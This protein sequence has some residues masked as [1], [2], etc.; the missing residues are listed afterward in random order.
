MKKMLTGIYSC[1]RGMI[2]KTWMVMRLTFF[3]MF[4]FLV[5]VSAS[6]YSQQT[7]LN[8]RTENASLEEVFKMIQEQSEFDFFYKTDQ[9]RGNQKISVDYKSSNIEDVL[10]EVL[11]GTGLN[12]HIL[13]KDIVISKS[14]MS[15]SFQQQ[16]IEL[17]GQILD[18]NGEPLPGVTVV[19][20]GT[21]N[22]VI[23]D[24]NGNYLLSNVPANGIVVFSFVGMHTIEQEVNGQTTINITMEDE[25]I[26]LEE[27]V[28]IGYGTVKKSDLT[29]SVG[30]VKGDDIANR[31]VTQVSQAL[32]GTISGVMVTRNN[33]APGSTASIRIRG[34]TTI[35]NSEPLVIVDG[36]PVG[37]INDVNPNDIESISVLKDAASASIYGSRAA[38]G[39]I[40][41]TTKRAKTGELSIS[42]NAEY[43]VEVPTEMAD[44]V[45]AKRYMQMANEL[46]WN[47]NGNNEG[48][49]YPTYTSD[50]VDNY[51][52]L[53]QE[54]PDLYPDTDWIDLVLKSNAPRQSHTISISGG[55]K[56]IRSKASMAYDEIDGLYDGRNYQRL[57]ARFN[58][59]VTIND[60]LSASL[61]FF[62]KRSISENA[63]LNEGTIVYY[64]RISA[65]VYAAEWT[66]GMVAEGKSGA[67]I[68]GQVKHGGEKT[69][70][71]NQVGGKAALNFT[72][73]QGLKLS[74]IIAP[75]LNYNKS[76]A[77]YKKVEYTDY[78]NPSAAVGTL[79]WASSTRLNE[80]RNDNYRVTTQFI[81]NYIKSFGRNN[82]N[83]MGGYENYYAFNE[84]LSA[85]S[86][87]LELT[88]YPYL[89]LGNENY[90]SNGG[91]AY[92]NAYRSWF[93]RVLY[94]FDNK[95]FFQGNMRYDGSS[96]FDEDYRWG[97]FPSFSLGWVM[98]EEAFLKN[99]STLSF[100][101]LRASWGT[102]G[103]ERLESYYPYQ[104]TIAFGSALFYQGNNVVSA[105]TAAQRYYAI[106]DISWETTESYDIGLDA[107][108]I[109]N[110]LRFTGDIYKKI[111][112]D[113][114][115][116]L[117]IPDYIGFDNPQ[118]NTGEME[119][120]GWEIELSWN[121]RIGELGYS[122]AA[123]LSDS[124]SEM[125]ELGGIQFLGDQVKFE[126]SEFNEWYGYLSD[127]IY[128]TQE[129][130]DNSATLNSSVGVGDIRYKDISGPDGVP[131]GIISSDYDK[132]LLGGSLPRYLFGGNIQ[133]D[134]KGFDFALAFQGVAKQKAKMS[135][136][137]VQPFAEN[138]GNFPKL[139]D[140]DYWSVYNSDEVN[141]QVAYP[142]L[143]YKSAG[144]NY[145]MSDYWLFNGAY[146]RVKNITLG[147]TLPAAVVD[148]LHLKSVR[149]YGSASDVLSINK[150]PKG[151]DPEVAG[152]G[153]P[154]TS[155]FILGVSVKF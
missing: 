21:T 112:K 143:S 131:D 83:L 22:G 110:K 96:R 153:Y 91:G 23:S 11:R 9:I 59:D 98:S 62:V 5:H 3:F 61:D 55:S 57:T 36:V 33:N 154:I 64:T 106:R 123:N 114:L 128:Q 70:W 146:F 94:N 93:G 42:Y 15:Q 101:K 140:G 25:T 85:G 92:E 65:P 18:Q 4:F 133:L 88:S 69:N 124:R 50:V 86:D 142:R 43:G 51:E 24:F 139:I 127:G 87:Q 120:K 84:G 105:Q 136:R 118:Q 108:F 117:E 149:V 79:Q 29:G 148:K 76:K 63:S 113:M 68:Y 44:F 73:I 99:N 97:L 13:D 67:N 10:E 58:N 17:K 144:N 75:E 100:L 145:S 32:Q 20:K 60:Y 107:S 147:Y 27:V 12:Y 115:L 116:D 40:L 102:L 125:G 109:N 150:Y 138:W 38:A 137:M 111:T 151:W 31:Q 135:S 52:T 155:S 74:A 41:V 78:D 134:Y 119:T 89:D 54:N 35:G 19:V 6:V 49:E 28:A 103:N 16:F 95:Y 53:H 37:G 130:V 141:Q 46:K 80:E 82:L 14:S 7:K 8:L 121:D 132:V 2:Q 71:Y 77:F 81:A 72:P 30:S 122:V 39:V 66:N 56:S 48:G 34:I 126:G 104:S 129:E 45:D 1:R 47:D 26:G 152:D 90:L